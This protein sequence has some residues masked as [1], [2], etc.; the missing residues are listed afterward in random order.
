MEW[1]PRRTNVAASA[2][3]TAGLMLGNQSIWVLPLSRIQGTV[4][5][6]VAKER[7]RLLQLLP[8]M[9]S[10]SCSSLF[11]AL[12]EM[13]GEKPRTEGEGVGIVIWSAYVY[14]TTQLVLGPNKCMIGAQ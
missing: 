7:L 14:W 1:K 5:F 13:H 11:V 12:A 2:Q 8:L 10:S 4:F 3:A 6:F 9:Q